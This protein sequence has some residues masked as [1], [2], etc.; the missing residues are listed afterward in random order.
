MNYRLIA[1]AALLV[2]AVSVVSCIDPDQTEE[3]ILDQNKE[4]IE[5]YLLENPMSGVKEY[6]EAEEGVYMFW[7]VSVDPNL[8]SIKSLDTVTVDYT[9]KFLSNSV[10]D[11][12]IEQVAKDNG[13]FDS[14]RKYGPLKFPIGTGRGAIIGFEFAVSLMKPGEKATVIFPSRLGYGNQGQGKIPP[15]APLIFELELIDVKKG[16]NHD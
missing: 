7:E 4:E 5:K 11:T 13:V 8:N 15:K 14:Q 12:S 3:V 9:G 16:P 2:G 6:K 10:F 1:F